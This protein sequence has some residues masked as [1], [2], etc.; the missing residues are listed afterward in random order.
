M[1]LKFYTENPLQLENDI[2]QLVESG[3]LRTWE[4]QEGV[5]RDKYLIHTPI[6][7]RGKGAIEL[8]S[9]DD[10]ENTYLEVNVIVANEGDEANRDR[11]YFLG[12]FCELMFVNFNNRFSVIEK[13][14]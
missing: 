11:G 6:Q 12:R 3:K 7:W 10:E 2:M 1:V 14:N 13:Y 8:C 5:M 9:A 4:V